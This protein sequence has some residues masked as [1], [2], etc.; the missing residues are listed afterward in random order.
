MP[1]R[2]LAGHQSG[3]QRIIQ[4]VAVEPAD[5]AEVLR[6]EIVRRAAKTESATTESTKDT[7]TVTFIQL[8][9]NGKDAKEHHLA[10]VL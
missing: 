8:D 10:E 5:Q 4:Q 3:S 1:S 9:D 6:H 7:H 2:Q